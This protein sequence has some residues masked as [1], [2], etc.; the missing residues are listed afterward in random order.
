MPFSA[1]FKKKNLK[2]FSFSAIQ[3]LN[4][5]FNMYLSLGKTNVNI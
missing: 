1:F 2:M 5:H 4:L 3:F